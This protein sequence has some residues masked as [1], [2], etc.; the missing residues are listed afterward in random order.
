MSLEGDFLLGN[1]TTRNVLKRDELGLEIAQIA[2]PTALALAADPIASLIDTAFI[3]HI[4]M[5]SR[6][7]S[8]LSLSRQELSCY[9]YH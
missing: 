1:S 3:G 7:S 2:L 8:Y 5:P 9:A 6:C 4:G